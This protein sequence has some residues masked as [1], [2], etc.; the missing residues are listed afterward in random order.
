MT[1]FRVEDA[2][3]SFEMTKLGVG[4]TL[5]LDE[6]LVELQAATKKVVKVSKR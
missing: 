6:P 4:M 3:Y 1:F 2:V 5:S